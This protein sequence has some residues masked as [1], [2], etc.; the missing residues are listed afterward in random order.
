MIETKTYRGK[1]E[2]KRKKQKKEAEKG[3][4]AEHVGRIRKS[5]FIYIIALYGEEREIT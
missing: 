3:N 2:K 4:F 1:K 5:Y